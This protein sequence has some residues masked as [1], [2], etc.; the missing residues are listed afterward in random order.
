MQIRFCFVFSLVVLLLEEVLILKTGILVRGLKLVELVH[1]ILPPRAIRQLWVAHIL[2]LN[3]VCSR[4][5]LVAQPTNGQR[6]VNVVLS[7]SNNAPS[8]EVVAVNALVFTA[9]ATRLLLCLANIVVPEQ[10][11][12]L[13]LV[14]HNA[15]TVV[16][17]ITNL[18]RLVLLAGN[19]AR[20]VFRHLR[21][22][23][24]VVST[25]LTK[26]NSFF[27]TTCLEH[28]DSYTITALSSQTCSTCDKTE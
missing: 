2:E 26:P 10:H 25:F 27:V 22:V 15:R 18:Q 5:L 28:V 19:L 3:Q 13:V 7:T 20:L 24:A 12:E 1:H 17:E 11:A 8:L 21:I 6:V 4:H 14:A 16:I 23:P 9:G